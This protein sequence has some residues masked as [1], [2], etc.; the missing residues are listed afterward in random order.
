MVGMGPSR[1]GAKGWQ[2][3]G[4]D[5]IIDPG[6][7]GYEARQNAGF[8]P[9]V[10]QSVGTVASTGSRIAP[11]NQWRHGCRPPASTERGRR[12]TEGADVHL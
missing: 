4:H 5:S 10:A 2:P 8:L 6:Y 9:A 3:L 7:D 1:S 11:M 12:R